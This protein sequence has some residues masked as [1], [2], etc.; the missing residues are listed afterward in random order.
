MAKG[1]RP[2]R[3]LL[4]LF[5][6]VLMGALDIAIVGPALPAIGQSFG[7]SAKD[8]AWVFTIYVLFNVVGVPL[9]SKLADRVGRRAVYVADVALFGVG[10]IAVAA[11]PSFWMLL[12]GRAMQGFGAG[13]IFPVATAV[14]GEVFPPERRGRALGL[15]GSVFGIAFLVGPV[16]GGALLLASWHWLFIINVPV[17]AILAASALRLLQD[18]RPATRRPF[19]L[20]GMGVLGVLLGAVV[21]G[22]SEINAR[23]LF[24]SL[25]SVQVWL[26]LLLALGLA[27][28]F[29]YVE[30]GAKD[31]VVRV[32]LLSSRQVVLASTLAIGAGLGEAGAVF[33]PSMAQSAFEVS[34]STAS[35]MLLPM[36]IAL[37]M[38]SPVVGRLLDRMGSR[39]VVF[40][41]AAL[42][43][44]GMVGIGFFATSLAGYFA[45][46]VLVGFGLAGV[47]GAPL[48]YIM[49][50]EAGPSEKASAQGLLTVFT[51]IGQLTGG[52]VIGAVATST[53]GGTTGFQ[54]AFLVLGAVALIITALS[55]KL[56]NHE[57]ELATIRR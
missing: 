17:A 24:T 15:L 38:G 30:R 26:P 41:S 14:V 22:L 51:S 35:F 29:W 42:L 31:P 40:V 28:A 32:D 16:L 33:F 47:L 27:P 21:F 25:T 9:M 6:G 20:A 7:V 11:A 34:H 4:L 39:T 5:F 57:E 50:G 8:L 12:V 56:K 48:R 2:G 36:M 18:G 55:T 45:A 3:V 10:S 44:A 1:T 19:D 54:A 52:A 53:G 37:G 13:G 23:S 46:S 43:T 49:L